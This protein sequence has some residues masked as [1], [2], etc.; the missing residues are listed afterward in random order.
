MAGTSFSSFTG[1]LMAMIT[2][3]L[4]PA[5]VFLFGVLMD[6]F[7]KEAT[8]SNINTVEPSKS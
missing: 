6:S 4:L 8:M 7:V 3:A 2:G 1:T 5:S